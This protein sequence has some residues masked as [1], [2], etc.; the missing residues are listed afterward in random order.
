MEKAGR[1]PER[2]PPGHIRIQRILSEWVRGYARVTGIS[3]AAAIRW[4]RPR[5][6]PCKFPKLI[7]LAIAQ[8][9]LT[10]TLGQGL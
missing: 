7:S 3:D 2:V 1:N 6:R 8:N 5:T 9:I 10:G 4:L